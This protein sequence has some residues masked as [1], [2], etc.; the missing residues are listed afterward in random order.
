M[1]KGL[2]SETTPKGS[3]VKKLAT[4]WIRV[5]SPA[6]P[7]GGSAPYEQMFYWAA[8]LAPA[9][10]LVPLAHSRSLTTEQGRRTQESEVGIEWLLTLYKSLCLPTYQLALGWTHFANRSQH[11]AVL[12][13]IGLVTFTLT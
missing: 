10:G 7:A 9:R 13:I 4:A 8:G 3:A 6:G 5:G 2:R 1:P 12:A 11:R